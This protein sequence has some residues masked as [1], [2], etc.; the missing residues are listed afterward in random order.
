[1]PNSPKPVKSLVQQSI[2]TSS[3][4]KLHDHS[5]RLLILK[6]GVSI[7]LHNLGVS[8]ALE[9][10][11]FT[12]EPLSPHELLRSHGSRCGCAAR[13]LFVVGDLAVRALELLN[14]NSAVHVGGFVHHT[15]FSVTW[16]KR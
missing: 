8:Q 3:S 4:H 11:R 7:V 16:H 15:V 1:M 9:K 13:G 10:L 2:Q 14:S 12:N 6:V 5:K